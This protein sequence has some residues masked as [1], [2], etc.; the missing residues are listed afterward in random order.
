[1]APHIADPQA[2]DAVLIAA[3]A[4]A[5]AAVAAYD[6]EAEKEVP[7]DGLADLYDRERL[8]LE[9][10]AS[11]RAHT[12]HGI[13]RKALLLGDCPMSPEAVGVAMS[14]AEDAVALVRNMAGAGAQTA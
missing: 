9:C 7:G 2:H 11:T 3:C 10:V 1:M 5:R 13:A 4:A 6:A 12:P 14:L 8:A